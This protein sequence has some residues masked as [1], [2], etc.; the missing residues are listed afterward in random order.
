MKEPFLNVESKKCLEDFAFAS[1]AK[2]DAICRH[3]SHA[4]E[5]LQD[6][7]MKIKGDDCSTVCRLA[8]SEFSECTL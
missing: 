1:A 4:H 2:L 7:E 6:Y 3:L 5:M 8:I